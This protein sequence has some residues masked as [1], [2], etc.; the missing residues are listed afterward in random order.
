MSNQDN[1]VPIRTGRNLTNGNG[2]ND[3]IRERLT[4]LEE[5]VSHLAS[6]EDMQRLEERTNHLASKEDVQRLE[7]RTNHLASKEDVQRIKVWILV[8]IIGAAPVLVTMVL[9]VTKFLV[10]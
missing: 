2:G 5:R 1:I 10:S 6:K 7:E 4:S 3:G 8:G 9:L